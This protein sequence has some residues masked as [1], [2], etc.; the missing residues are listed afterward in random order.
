MLFLDSFRFLFVVK[1]ITYY[2]LFHN[3]IV[4]FDYFILLQFMQS[5]VIR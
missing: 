3:L 1:F 2:I 5:N 4:I